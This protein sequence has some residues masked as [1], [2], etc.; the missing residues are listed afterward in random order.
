MENVTRIVYTN[1]RSHTINL[2]NYE[3]VQLDKCINSLNV[4]DDKTTYSDVQFY[5]KV[6][7]ARLIFKGIIDCNHIGYIRRNYTQCTNTS[8]LNFYTTQKN[9]RGK[10]FLKKGCGAI[11]FSLWFENNS[12][13][14]VFYIFNNVFSG[15]LKNVDDVWM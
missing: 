14:E 15:N 8:I 2:V 9:G 7:G 4:I 12:K 10:L 6:N 3:L 1:N 11:N 5:Y 13:V